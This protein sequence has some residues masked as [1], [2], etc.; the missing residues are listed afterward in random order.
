MPRRAA[1]IVW[2]LAACRSSQ[3]AAVPDRL[4]TEIARES[5][6]L[7]A[8][9]STDEISVS[10]REAAGPV[11]EQAQTALRQGRRLLALQRLLAAAPDLEAA[12]YL[13]Q[14]MAAGVNDPAGFEA[15]WKRMGGV[16]APQLA[17]PS[18]PAF[19]GVR[20]AA[21]RAFAEAA[22][23]QVRLYYE[24]SLE[25]GRNTMPEAGLFYLGAAQAER[26]QV[27]MCREMAAR[28]EAGAAPGPALRGLGGELDRLEA[29]ILAAYRPPASIDRHPQ[30]IAASSML[31]EARELDGAGLRHGAL[32]R[33][34]QAVLL[35]APLRRAA[36]AADRAALSRD[37]RALDARLAGADHSVARLFVEVAEADLEAATDPG[38]KTAAVVSDVL[39]RY[40]AAL[41]PAP[42]VAASP[43]AR[44]TV[45]LVRWPFT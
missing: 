25:Y 42:P 7:R 31:K 39:P 35:S 2:A 37:L 18:A 16:L 24:A 27:A 13:R 26:D 1:L 44:V 45:T 22:L 36:S 34:L 4:A 9:S 33:Y 30:F 40:F 43:A 6:L 41:E 15:E 5:S 38:V 3:P 21:L 29:E 14:R 32:L 17:P 20:P 8:D 23:P 10:V 11:M 19:D 12:R 28:W